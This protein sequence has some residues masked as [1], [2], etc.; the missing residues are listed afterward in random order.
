[1]KIYLGSENKAKVKALENVAK[2]FFEEFKAETLEL[3][4]PDQ[5]MSIEEAMKGAR[6]RARQAFQEEDSLGVGIEG[7]VETLNERKIL[8]VWTTIY[9]GHEFYEGGSGNIFFIQL[10][11]YTFLLK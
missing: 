7:Y 8:S 6:K 4:S 3:K 9:D 2:E 10:S 5:P 11:R 1:M